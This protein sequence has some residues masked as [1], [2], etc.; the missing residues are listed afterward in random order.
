M[1]A[2]FLDRLVAMGIIAFAKVLTG[3]RAYWQDVVPSPARRVYF[4]NH[5]SHGDFVLIWASLP[6]AIRWNTRPVAGSDYW[7]TTLLKRYIATRALNAV[8][9]DR[10]KGTGADQD[11]IAMMAAATDAGASLIVF[12]EGTRNTTEAKLLPFKSGIYR[13][14]QARPELEFVPCWIENLNRVLP[15]GEVLP[16]PLLCTTTFGPPLKLAAGEDKEAF[17]ARARDAMLALAPAEQR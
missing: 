9:I 7:F 11:P 8:L 12:P 5:S 4:G 10:E 3:V 6:A 15:K 17:L 16:V 1:A 2:R 13:L 14:A